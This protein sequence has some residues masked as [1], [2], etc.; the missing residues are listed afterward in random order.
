MKSL[1]LNKYQ[2]LLPLFLGVAFCFGLLAFRIKLSYEFFYLILVWNLFLGIVPLV[3]VYFLLASAEIKRLPLLFGTLIWLL[4][5]P[6]APYIITDLIH[7][8]HSDPGW[9]VVDS[10]I[11][12]SFAI[13]SALAG[14]ISLREMSRIYKPLVK[15]K[16][17][18]AAQILILFLCGYGVYLGRFIRF[19]SWELVTNPLP[20]FEY[21]WA[22]VSHPLIYWKVW[23]FTLCFGGFLNLTYFTGIF[24]LDSKTSNT[25]S[26]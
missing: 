23:G 21:I 8:K 1:I 12:M 19:N 18:L 24:V 7:L 5:L 14:F 6:N 26:I 15:I 11:I 13:V 10:L 22:T 2:Q 4:F 3:T 20:L 16:G 17:L 9:A 25:R